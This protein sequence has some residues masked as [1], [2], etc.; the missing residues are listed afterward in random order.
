LALIHGGR[1]YADQ[2]KGL[3]DALGLRPTGSWEVAMRQRIRSHLSY[4]NVISTLALFLVLCGGTSL[5]MNGDNF[6]LGQQNSAGSPTRLSSPTTDA[7]GALKVT[8][9]AT[10]GGRAIQGTS[11]HGQGVYGHSDSN[12][13]VVG[14]SGTFDGVFGVSNDS[15]SAGVSGHGNGGGYGIFATGGSRFFGTA[16]IH[17]QSGSGN[18]I[19]GYSNA[20]PSSGVYGQDNNANSYGV[21]GHSGNGVAVA[22][23]SSSG[24]AMQALGNA[25]QS[26]TSGGFVKAMAFVD[27]N[28][29]PAD[30]IRECFNAQL[31]KS[32]ATGP[33]GDCGMSFNRTIAGL[34]FLDFGFQVSD[35]F[36]SVTGG[37]FEDHITT[38]QTTAGGAP[39]LANSQVRIEVWSTGTDHHEEGQFYIFVY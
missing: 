27:P 13:G 18:A 35:R 36:I 28:G 25:T 3:A 12:A 37:L 23:D 5:A 17:G 38:V 30:P 26:R 33:P 8:S 32:Q 29:H 22:G 10:S 24:W 6:I 39:G 4:A 2:P 11:A 14:D 1:R 19:E 16:A 15:N 21:V 34:Y 9:T 7:A 31:S 20:N